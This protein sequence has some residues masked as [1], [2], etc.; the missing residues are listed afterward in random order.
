MVLFLR[1]YSVLTTT[2]LL[3][4]FSLTMLVANTRG[5][6]RIDPLGAVF[7]E[8]VTP[9]SRALSALSNVFGQAWDSY[10]GLVGVRQENAW[11]RKRVRELEAR[12]DRM[13]DL[14]SQ[15]ARLQALLDLRDSMPGQA[16]AARI[17]SA[18]LKGLF[19]TATLNKGE[20]DGIAQG[21]AVVAPQGAVGH[22]VATSPNA[23]RVLLL[24]DPSSGIDAIVQRSRA[25]G[26]VEGGSGSGCVLKYVKRRD[27][28]QPGD[29]VVTSGLD[30]IF[31]KGIP[32]GEITAVIPGE[33]GLFQS[34]ELQAA[35]DFSKLE[36]VLV[37]AAPATEVPPSPQRVRPTPAERGPAR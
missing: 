31:P 22:V 37:V 36:E 5:G 23:A 35:I 7:L 12:F 11:L 33:R 29:R 14:E 27:D 6:R 16:V 24:E 30:G 19:R 28:L 4:A 17:T 1:R 32:I 18:D 34:A 10:V 2:A 20:R 15:S 13:A 26:I 3:L 25:R 9:G 8:I 21:M